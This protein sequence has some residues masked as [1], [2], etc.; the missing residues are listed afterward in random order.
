MG[1]EHPVVVYGASGYTGKLVA[2][3][4]AARGIPFVAAGRNEQRLEEGI[5]HLEKADAIT[6]VVSHDAESLT[7]L[8]AGAEVVINVTGP[9]GQLG[10]TV[11]QAALDADCHY[12]DTT[13]EQD[14]TMAMKAEFHEAYLA[15]ERVLLP[16]LAWMWTSGL[17]AA[18]VCLETEGVDSLDIVYFPRG[19]ASIAST[20]SFMRMNCRPNY[21]LEDDQL[22]AWPEATSHQ[23]TVPYSHRVH[24]ALPWGGG[25]EPVWFSDDPRVRNCSVLTAFG[26]SDFIDVLVNSMKEYHKQ[27]ETLSEEELE[28]LTNTWGGNISSTPEREQFEVNRFIVSCYGRGT[29]VV[30]HCVIGGTAPYIQTGFLCAEGAHRLLNG[31]GRQAGFA[32]AA[33]VFGAR[34]L[35]GR[36]ADAGM[37]SRV[38]KEG[39]GEADVA[40]SVDVV[41]NF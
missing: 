11:V 23:V 37:Q 10:R 41:V 35:L 26:N 4:L 22:V 24:S 21:F 5:A 30:N 12:L 36:L 14:F 38:G 1:S 2:E 17:L 34:E 29:Q 40:D 7:E 32:S 33:Q 13:G 19:Q 20:K 27:A 9:F 15:K 28:E 18:E 3:N 6:K 25:C 31:Q 39:I 16:A 8:F